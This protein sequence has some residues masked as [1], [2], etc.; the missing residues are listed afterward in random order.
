KCGERVAWDDRIES[1][2]FRGGVADVEIRSD[3]TLACRC[4]RREEERAATCSSIND[5]HR[6]WLGDAREIEKLVVLAERRLAAALRRSL[7]DRN[8]VADRFHHSR[9]TRSEF[10][11]RKLVGEALLCL[12]QCRRREERDYPDQ[13]MRF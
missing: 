3:R 8:A 1:G 13:C 5:E 10:L 11:G 7:Q 4:P 9:A 6:A 2:R 12:R